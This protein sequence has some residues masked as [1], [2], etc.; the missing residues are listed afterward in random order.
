MLRSELNQTA[1][2]QT[3]FQF[4]LTLLKK[5]EKIIRSYDEMAKIQQLR[6]QAKTRM[7]A[8]FKRPGK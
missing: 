3:H 6:K 4:E 5:S 7:N 1:I 8:R 2:Q